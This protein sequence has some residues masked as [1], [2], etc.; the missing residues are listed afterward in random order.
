MKK[1]KNAKQAKACN[2]KN[3]KSCKSSKESMT[4]DNSVGFE[5]KDSCDTKDCNHSSR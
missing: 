2:C 3:C 5:S 1:D 4:L